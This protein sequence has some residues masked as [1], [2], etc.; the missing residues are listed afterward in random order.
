MFHNALLEEILQERVVSS[1]N[2]R[3]P[4]GVK[5]KTSS[6]PKRP[7]WSET[8]PSIDIKKLLLSLCEQY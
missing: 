3:S 4:R 6:F 5:R 1:R 7:Q 2:R 8:L